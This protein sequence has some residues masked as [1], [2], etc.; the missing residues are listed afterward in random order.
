MTHSEILAE[1][2]LLRKVACIRANLPKPLAARQLLV[3]TSGLLI[4]DAI[5]V[6]M[7]S[8]APGDTFDSYSVPKGL[9][10]KK[11]VVTMEV[12]RSY[13]HLQ[14]LSET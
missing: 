12:P 8:I 2:S 1:V 4:E 9:G 5:V 10:G 7:S 6:S 11:N 13:V 3:Q 14:P